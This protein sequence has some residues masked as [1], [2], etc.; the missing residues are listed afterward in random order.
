MKN[1]HAVA[2]RPVIEIIVYAE[3]FAAAEHSVRGFAAKLAVKNT[4]ARGECRSVHRNGYDIADR[5]VRRVGYYLQNAVFARVNL[6]DAEPF[7]IW[8]L[9]YFD[10]F[11]SHDL[12]ELV[13]VR[14]NLLDLESAI[15]KFFLKLFGRDVYIHIIFKPT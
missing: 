9:S 10:Y 15:E 12:V 3:F 5:H 13:S 8:V 14:N 1:K 4:V 2:R 7:R 6:T 11:T